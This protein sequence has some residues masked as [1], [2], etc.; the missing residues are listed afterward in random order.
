MEN[1]D[2]F[3]TNSLAEEAKLVRFA[4]SYNKERSEW[5]VFP[6]LRSPFLKD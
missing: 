4:N 2:I 5:F 6:L 1:E 3:V